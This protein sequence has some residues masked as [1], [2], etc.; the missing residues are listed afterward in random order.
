M[1]YPLIVSP[2]F[3]MNIPDNEENYERF[4]EFYKKYKD[5]WI[6]IFIIIDDDHNSLIEN[7]KII[8]ASDKALEHPEIRIILDI[9]FKLKKYKYSNVKTEEKIDINNISKYLKDRGVKKIV[10]FP[11]YFND[12]FINLKKL[13]PKVNLYNSD[14]HEVI[15]EICSITRF[16]KKVFL[17]DAMIPY[18]ISNLQKIQDIKDLS[19]DPG[20]LSIIDKKNLHYYKIGF[21]HLI[22]NIYDTNFFQNELEIYIYTTL[23]NSKLKKIYKYCKENN[24]DIRVEMWENLSKYISNS[25]KKCISSEIE[26]SK[27]CVKE[28]FIKQHFKDGKKYNDSNKIN[29]EVYD[30]SIFVL[31]LNC[32][33]EIRKGIDLFDEKSDNGLRSDSGYY[34][35]N[36][37]EE[38]EL[39]NARQIIE[40][41]DYEPRKVYKS[42]NFQL[43]V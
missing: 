25:V 39:E 41:P 8:Y 27:N 43:R 42:S 23:H 37:L 31:D 3:I 6:D 21:K 30:R 36:Y 24:D 11:N 18:C 33:I 10:E 12:E 5:V 4:V 19:D 32:A 22:K 15:E 26:K 13:Q 40:H 16:S 28:I 29:F 35:R 38:K 2:Q 20:K 9:L 34:I 7:Y 1:L 14:Y 17:N